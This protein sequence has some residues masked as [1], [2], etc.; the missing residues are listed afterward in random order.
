MCPLWHPE[1]S[2]QAGETVSQLGGTLEA[3]WESWMSSQRGGKSEH[4]RLGC[5]LRDPARRTAGEKRLRVFFSSTR[6]IVFHPCCCQ[7][8]NE[9]FQPGQPHIRCLKP[10]LPVSNQPQSFRS[11]SGATSC[12]YTPPGQWH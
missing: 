8:Y 3:S 7:Q 1:N 10:F 9:E 6:C 2:E 4:L 5:C 11:P 12:D